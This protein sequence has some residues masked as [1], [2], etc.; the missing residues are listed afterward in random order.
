MNPLMQVMLFYAAVIGLVAYA[1]AYAA[2][3]GYLSVTPISGLYLGAA[4]G[5]AASSLL[6][7]YYGAAYAGVS[8]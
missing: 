5:S 3:T 4:I 8:A 1:G 7:S 6:W 2:S